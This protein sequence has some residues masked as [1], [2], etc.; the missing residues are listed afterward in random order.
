MHSAR[1]LRTGRDRAC[2]PGIEAQYEHQECGY[3]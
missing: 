2:G 1:C 3:T